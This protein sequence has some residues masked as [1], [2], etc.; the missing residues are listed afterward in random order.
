MSDK[1]LPRIV[2]VSAGR[3]PLKQHITLHKNRR[4]GFGGVHMGYFRSLADQLACQRQRIELDYCHRK[5]E[6]HQYLDEGFTVGKA[7]RD[8]EGRAVRLNNRISMPDLV[9]YKEDRIYDLKTVIWSLIFCLPR[10]DRGELSRFTGDEIVRIVVHENRDQLNRYLRAYTIAR[11]RMAT[12]MLSIEGFDR[13]IVCGFH[14]AAGEWF[15][16][17]DEYKI[18]S[19]ESSWEDGRAESA[20]PK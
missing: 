5:K 6:Y 18:K 15:I 16:V 19:I 20:G 9:D 14:P 11:G 1:E 7:I 13:R 12:I 2:N 3:M 10:D 8:R 17:E 4:G